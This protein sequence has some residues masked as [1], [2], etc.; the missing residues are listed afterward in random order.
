M[1]AGSNAGD[2]FLEG[3]LEPDARTHPLRTY[4]ID[5]AINHGLTPFSGEQ[6]P[7]LSWPLDLGRP[8]AR[9][10]PA[11]VRIEELE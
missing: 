11:N 3:H 5:L 7:C 10:R 1:A 4:D 9:P 6:G 2:Y 8:S